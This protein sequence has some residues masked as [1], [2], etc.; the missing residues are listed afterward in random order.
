LKL[1]PQLGLLLA[2]Q[3]VEN[4]KTVD[5]FVIPE[6]EDALHQAVL[7]AQPRM[8]QWVSGPG[9]Y[10]FVRIAYHP[11]GSLLAAS[12]GRGFERP[13]TE[14]MDIS[15]GEVLRTLPGYLLS[16][17]WVEEDRLALIYY[18]DEFTAQ[19]SLRNIDTGEEIAGRSIP[20]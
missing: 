4:T 19:Y 20:L 1:D 8:H 7:I 15:T 16:D 2:L 9:G 10:T 13:V 5:G 14:I 17:T 3:A 11:S 6:A 12:S 18:L